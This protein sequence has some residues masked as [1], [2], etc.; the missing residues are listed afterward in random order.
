MSL[1][2]EVDARIVGH[3]AASP[4]CISDGSVGW[5]GLGPVS[6]SRTYQSQGIGFALIRAA[7]QCLAQTHAAGC[8]V[9]GEPGYYRRFGFRVRD[10]LNF[11]SVP[12]ENFQA[13]AFRDTW[14][15][16][17]VTYHR[18]FTASP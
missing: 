15:H 1:V 18:A 16:G 10:D 8:V 6:V 3:V 12:R 9:L 11:P 13:L 17:V 14:P 5:F 2:A 7:L 4:V